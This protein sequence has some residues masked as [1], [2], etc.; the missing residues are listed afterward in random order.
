MTSAVTFTGVPVYVFGRNDLGNVPTYSYVNL[1]FQ[2]E[3]RLPKNLRATVA[4]NIDNLF[5]QET[6]TTIVRDALP[7]RAELQSVLGRD[8]RGEPQLRGSRVLRRLRH[9]SGDGRRER[10]RP[11]QRRTSRPALQDG[12]GLAGRASGAAPG[13]VLVLTAR[14]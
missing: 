2:Q 11:E 3:F 6:V 5:D 7:R 13:A 12:L 14:G 1:N 8:G 4:L 10:R 9:E